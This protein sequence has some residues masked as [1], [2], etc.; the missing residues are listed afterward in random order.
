M[1]LADIFRQYW[2]SYLT[3]NAKKVLPSHHAA[4]RAIMSCHTPERGG[5]LYQCESGH[6][7]Y[8][9]HGCGHRSCPQCGNSDEWIF[10]QTQRLLPVNYHLVTFTVP[11]EL[12][13]IIRSHQRLL[14]EMLF[15][16]SAATMQA[17]AANPKNLGGELALIGALHTWSRQLIYH[18]HIHY[19]VP[20]VA[21][22]ADE[23]LVSPKN[24]DYL[25]AVQVLSAE[26]RNRF[27][28]TLEQ[29]APDLLKE[30]PKSV[31]NKKW[32]VHSKPVGSGEHALKY[33]ARYI[34]KTAI[35]ADHN[36][37]LN[38]DYVLFKYEDRKSGNIKT[39]KLH[40]HEFMRRV[41]Q[42]VL[43]KRFRRVRTYGWLSPAA[44]KRFRHVCQKLDSII[45]CAPTIVVKIIKPVCCQKCN[46]PMKLICTFERGPP[47]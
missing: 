2:Q 22:K 39:I 16:Q 8:T 17:V 3:S 21:L 5:S 36:F 33:L 6:K 45:S 47:A 24:P 1:R 44:K 26:F 25:L 14:L 32:V 13:H 34:H 35:S 7:L 31:W 30:I 40:A 43:L 9:Y 20:G 41:L 29:C 19:I 10:R 23:S 38:G 15:A 12:R 27:R 46:Q 37:V 18:P 11:R 42:H 28:K 4:A